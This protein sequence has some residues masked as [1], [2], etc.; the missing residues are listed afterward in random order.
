VKIVV[1][2]QLLAAEP[3]HVGMNAARDQVGAQLLCAALC[4]GQGAGLLHGGERSC[5]IHSKPGESERPIKMGA[6]WFEAF[7]KSGKPLRLHRMANEA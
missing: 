3:Q 7:G 5:G 1:R 2:E 6:H 4:F